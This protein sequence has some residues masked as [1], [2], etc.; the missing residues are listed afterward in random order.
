MR[1]A[2]DPVPGLKEELLAAGVRHHDRRRRRQAQARRAVSATAAFV[3]IAAM[4]VITLSW[5]DGKTAS[6]SVVVTRSG[7][8][9]EVVISPD[10][11]TAALVK[12]ALSDHGVDA[13]VEAVPV[14][15][16]RIGE[17]VSGDNAVAPSG[18]GPSGTSVRFPAGQS[19]VHLLVGR[20]A[21]PAETY[22][23]V[24]DAFA[25]GEP[26]ECV[27]DVWAQPASSALPSIEAAFDDVTILGDDGQASAATAG[28]VGDV[29]AI[30]PG[31]AVVRVH[32]TE[33]GPPPGTVVGSRKCP[34]R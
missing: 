25:A 12:D 34:L 4:A 11:A 22:L 19:R 6:A 3:I 7:D 14:G 28:I 21:E 13:L 15:P 24:S 30:G 33:T 23:A 29:L 27:D 10:V 1:T 20:P 2:T 26:L 18:N 16:S 9:F 17:F 31:R 8:M 5:P 32:E